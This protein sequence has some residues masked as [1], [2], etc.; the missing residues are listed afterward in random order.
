MRIPKDQRW[1]YHPEMQARIARAEED[2]ATGRFTRT[3]TPE[4][5]QAFLDGLKKK[6]KAAEPPASPKGPPGHP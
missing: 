2:F 1:F 6:S 5:A 4:E 3:N